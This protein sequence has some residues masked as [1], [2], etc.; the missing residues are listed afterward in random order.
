M[1]HAQSGSSISRQLRL[2]F[3]CLVRYLTAQLPSFGQLRSNQAVTAHTFFG[4]QILLATSSPK[5]ISATT[6]LRL[7]AVAP[8]AALAGLV[9]RNDT[10]F[11]YSAVSLREVGARNTLVS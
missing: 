7:L 1:G 11:D 10:D 3:G 2:L 6:L 8:A 5:M 4:F 9:V